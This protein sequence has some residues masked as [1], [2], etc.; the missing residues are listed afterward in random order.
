MQLVFSAL[1][2]PG[3]EVILSD[4]YYSCYPN[5]IKYADGVP[6]TVK[7]F[8]E[9][10]FRFSVE[11]INART[12][13]RTRGILINSPSNPTGSILPP[14]DLQALAQLG[15]PVI[16]DEI[17]HGLEYGDR[18]HSMLEFSDKAV[19]INGF[20]KLFAMTGWRLG[21]AIVPPEMVRPIRN[22]QQNL[23]ICAGSF[24]QKAAIAAL[25]YCDQHIEDM[26]TEYDKR[27]LYT[28]NRLNELGLGIKVSPTGAFYILANARHISMD[29]YSLA[30]DILEKAKVAVAPGI[31]FGPNAEGYLRISYCNSLENI[32]EGMDRLEKYLRDR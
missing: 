30:F 21:Y 5:F 19:V 9:N 18:A 16:S 12:S 20:S 29:S 27:R 8:E 3:D 14:E 24:V 15:I 7:V 23:F 1:L 31:D 6:V 10:G 13:P 17:Y 11:D 2:N 26:R 28:L 4:P 32:A 22:M 25:R